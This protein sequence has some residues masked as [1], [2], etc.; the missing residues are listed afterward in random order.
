MPYDLRLKLPCHFTL[1][2]CALL[3][4]YVT[5]TPG[6]RLHQA[7]WVLESYALS[8]NGI[9][10]AINEVLKH[11]QSSTLSTGRRTCDRRVAPVARRVTALSTGKT[12][13]LRSCVALRAGYGIYAQCPFSE[14]RHCLDPTSSLSIP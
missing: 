13:E 2:R 1:P 14:K 4:S 5:P 7:R 6:T 3:T 8:V 9:V 11:S 12:Y 10:L